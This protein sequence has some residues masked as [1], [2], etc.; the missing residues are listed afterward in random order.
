[1]QAKG[2][3]CFFVHGRGQLWKLLPWFPRSVK[4]LHGFENWLDT[5]MERKFNKTKCKVHG[6]QRALVLIPGE[7]GIFISEPVTADFHS[8]GCY[9]ALLDSRMLCQWQRSPKVP[10]EWAKG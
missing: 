7:V 4:S 1:M 10:V 6:G 5:F 8:S 3:R 2:S 9:E